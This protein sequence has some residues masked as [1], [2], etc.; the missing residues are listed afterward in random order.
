MSN[1]YLILGTLVPVEGLGTNCVEAY[2]CTV[3]RLSTATC[4]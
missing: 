2:T 3:E 4:S 1:L